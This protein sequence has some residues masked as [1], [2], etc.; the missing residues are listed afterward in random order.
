MSGRISRNRPVT[1]IK[2]MSVRARILSARATGTPVS[3][4][5]ARRGTGP[6]AQSGMSGELKSISD[7]EQPI[8]DLLKTAKPVYRPFRAGK[9]VHV[10]DVIHKCVRRIALLRR[11]RAQHQPQKL[12]DGHAITYAQGDAIHDFIKGRFVSGH[13]EKVFAKWRCGCGKVTTQPMLYSA[14]ATAAACAACG[15]K[16][17]NYVEISLED[18]E[19]EVVGSPDLALY[20]SEVDAY[21]LT[22][23]KSMAQKLWDELV[24]PVPDHVIQ[25]LFYWRLM[26]L[27]G[28]SMVE[29]Y[30]ILYVKKEFSFKLPYKEFVIRPVEQMHHLEPFLNDLDS[31]VAAKDPKAPL[32]ARTMCSSPTDTEAK[33]CPVCVT[34]FH[35]D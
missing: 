12:F 3:L 2:P 22:E 16:P 11:L 28:Y 5:Q 19:H 32:P 8:I 33:N 34:C 4:I 18:E 20:F 14:L 25:G 29:Q 1:P 26:R 23:V 6:I 31:L 7:P 13:P 10:S 27:K 15:Q 17:S 30:S 35:M 9:Y 21:Y 24:R